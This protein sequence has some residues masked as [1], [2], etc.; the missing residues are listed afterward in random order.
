M[1]N[2]S[3]KYQGNYLSEISHF[4][5]DHNY[6]AATLAC[7]S[8]CKVYSVIPIETFIQ[9]FTHN[10][11]LHQWKISSDTYK[12][13]S[14]YGVGTVN[15]LWRI[16]CVMFFSLSYFTRWSPNSLSTL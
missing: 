12:G 5:L 13:H 1:N 16:L 4:E 15:T 2:V 7:N 11:T 3:G 10:H 6:I 8:G 14:I 9:K